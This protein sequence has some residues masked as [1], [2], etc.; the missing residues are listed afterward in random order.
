VKVSRTPQ[1]LGLAGGWNTCIERA[2]GQWVHL[3]HHDDFVLPGFYA[4]M[5]AV[6]EAHPEVALVACRN[7]SVDEQGIILGV[8]PRVAELEPGGRA[9]ESFLYANPIQCPGVVVRRAFYEAHGGFRPDLLF[10]LDVEMWARAIGLAGGVVIPEV[11]VCYRSSQGQ[12]TN[13]LVRSGESLRDVERLMQIYAERYPDY[14]RKLFTLYFCDKTF[15]QARL[16]SKT[17]D[18][19]AAKANWSF[20]NKNFP[21]TMRLSVLASRVALTIARRLTFRI[22]EFSNRGHIV[23]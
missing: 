1:N 12:A 11:L 6:A 13:R 20:W 9:V 15:D 3:L 8:S 17:G 19:E 4:R 10:V 23:K 22:P 18:L 2:C 5:R 7:F 14:D 16:F 21:K